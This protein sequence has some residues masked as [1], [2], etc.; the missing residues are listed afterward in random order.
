MLGWNDSLSLGYVLI[1]IFIPIFFIA[2]LSKYLLDFVKI[3]LFVGKLQ[4]ECN[5]CEIG[6]KLELKEIEYY[7]ICNQSMDRTT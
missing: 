7:P 4:N 6:I 2:R 3:M 1:Q 5:R